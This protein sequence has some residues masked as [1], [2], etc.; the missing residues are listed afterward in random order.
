M[1]NLTKMA[2]IA[3]AVLLFASQGISQIASTTVPETKGQKKENAGSTS[4]RDTNKN[5][6]CD[7]FEARKAGKTGKNFVDKDG[8]GKCDNMGKNGK[9]NGN[10]CG[11]GPGCGQGAGKGKG[12][13]G[14]CG[15]GHQHCHRGQ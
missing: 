5:G 15:Q 4:F 1:K 8:D 13:G 12:N 11:A 2:L 3:A 7:N 6:I 9:G 14:Y 10:C